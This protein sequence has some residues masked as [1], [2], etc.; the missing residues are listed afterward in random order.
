M[1]KR[2]IIYSLACIQIIFS[3]FIPRVSFCSSLQECTLSARLNIGKFFLKHIFDSSGEL[4]QNDNI[5]ILEEEWE[6]RVKKELLKQDFKLIKR[7]GKGG[8]AFVYLALNL[9]DPNVPGFVAVKVRRPIKSAMI[10]SKEG[11]K[12][13]SDTLGSGSDALEKTYKGGEIVIDSDVYNYHVLEFADGKSVDKRIKEGFFKGLSPREIINV[14]IDITSAC[15][16]MHQKNLAHFDI[17]NRNIM[18]SD[19]NAVKVVDIENVLS[20]IP[21]ELKRV[22]GEQYYLDEW[23]KIDIYNISEVFLSIL[24]GREMNGFQEIFQDAGEIEDL[25]K[26]EA[27]LDLGLWDGYLE[28]LA[29]CIAKMQR[30]EFKD[31]GAVVKELRSIRE[32]KKNDRKVSEDA[33]LIKGGKVNIYTFR[34]LLSQIA[35]K[36]NAGLKD[37]G[38]GPLVSDVEIFGSALYLNRDGLVEL[39]FISD[40]DVNIVVSKEK[41][42]NYISAG[43]IKEMIIGRFKEECLA[44]TSREIKNMNETE[45][46]NTV[47]VDFGRGVFKMQLFCNEAGYG[48]KYEYLWSI[49]HELI[50]TDERSYEND[51]MFF[52]KKSIIFLRLAGCDQWHKYYEKMLREDFD[53]ADFETV[54]RILIGIQNKIIREGNTIITPDNIKKTIYPSAQKQDM[55]FLPQIRQHNNRMLSS[56]IIELSI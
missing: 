9:G 10:T 37:N 45:N 24:L 49:L 15:F 53:N 52:Q 17:N 30:N 50:S 31:V 25:I 41:I 51:K 22:K 46:K 32:F 4:L 55:E 2:K 6:S 11:M 8:N 35:R 14:F 18:I 23:K 34:T 43:Q 48:M 56:V 36:V 19:K 3:I 38:Y 16:F 27:N 7:V 1:E 13:L 29:Q 40:I 12:K 26:R 28:K 42:N 33:E 47:M 44:F 39:S 54:K 5:F 21:E 20:L